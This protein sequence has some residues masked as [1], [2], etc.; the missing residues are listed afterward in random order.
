MLGRLCV[1]QVKQQE[2]LLGARAC[3]VACLQEDLERSERLL[4]ESVTT[5]KELL[6]RSKRLIGK[7]MAL[8]RIRE[9]DRETIDNLAEKWKM[10][11][12]NNLNQSEKELE[13]QKR[14]NEDL[15]ASV[16]SGFSSLFAKYTEV[17]NHLG[18]VTSE[19]KSFDFK[20]CLEWLVEEIEGLEDVLTVFGDDCAML[21]S[22]AI[23]GVI[24][25]EGDAL[26]DKMSAKGYQFPSEFA[27]EATSRLVAPEATV[28]EAAARRLQEVGVR[29]ELNL[30][31]RFNVENILIVFN[32]QLN[33][34]AQEV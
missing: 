19:P 17:L 29:L 34:S 24:E 22:E 18:A 1:D 21:G 10:T 3:E 4:E 2:I 14:V 16:A 32:F 9:D 25:S 28:R 13:A 11:L 12:H 6:E 15:E 30:T 26:L 33:K 8:R 23:L 5:N 7:N 27:P 20:S 31:F